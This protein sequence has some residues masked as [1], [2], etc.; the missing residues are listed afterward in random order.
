MKIKYSIHFHVWTE[1]EIFELLTYLVREHQ[2]QMMIDAFW[3][4]N[5]ENV[6]IIRK[7]SA[8]AA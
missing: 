4:G 5:G 7:G 2:L 6:F 1:F 3:G 8:A